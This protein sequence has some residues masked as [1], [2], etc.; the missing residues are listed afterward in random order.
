MAGRLGQTSHVLV[1]LAAAV[2]ARADAA[3]GTELATRTASTTVSPARAAADDLARELA[4][5]S[6]TY[7]STTPL[8]RP[9]NLYSLLLADALAATIAAR[10]AAP[11]P[12]PARLERMTRGMVGAPYTFSPLGEAAEPD[13]D[14]RFRLDA[15]DCTTFVETALA[16]VRCD[17]L[18]EIQRELDRIRYTRGEVAY[19]KRRHLVTAQ[20]IPDLI[21]LGYVEE[22]TRAIGGDD[23]VVMTLALDAKRWKKRAVARKVSLDVADIPA[24]TFELPYL[25]IAAAIEHARRG[26]IPPGTI[27]NAVRREWAYS[28]E[29]ITHQGI[30]L[31]RPEDGALFVRHASPISKRVIDEPLLTMLG[32]YEKPR[33]P[34]AWPIIGINLLRI[35]DPEAAPKPPR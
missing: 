12:F 29:V 11:G 28:P 20:W 10:H 17:A 9:M 25:P 27:I 22:V 8:P 14:P 18:P 19:S 24:G 23:T 30:V 33:T 15:F 32:R 3:P 6:G 21:A 35:V 2:A 34:K 26:D 5:P 1:A 4:G 7:T 31:A 16:F 13:L